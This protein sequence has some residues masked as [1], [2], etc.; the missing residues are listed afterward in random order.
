MKVCPK[1]NKKALRVKIYEDGDKFYVHSRKRKTFC[2][3]VKGCYIKSEVKEA[4][5]A[6]IQG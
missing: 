4:M 2:Y 1:C 6:A 3:E 5:K